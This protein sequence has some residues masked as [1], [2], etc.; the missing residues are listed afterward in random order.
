MS[1]FVKTKVK[2]ARDAIGKK[3]YEK[4]C[5]LALGVLEYEPDNYHANLFLGLAYF[6]LKQY[7]ESEQTYRKAIAADP[8]QTL[9]WQGILKLYEE[10]GNWAEVLRTLHKLVELHAKSNDAV[11]CAE[12]IQKII[13]LRRDTERLQSTRLELAE[14]LSLLLPDSPFYPV[15]STLP[16]PDPTNP[17][18]STTFLAQS[19]IQD[20]LPILQELVSIHEQEERAIGDAEVAKRRQRLGALSPEETRKQVALEI[21]S[22]S[23][24]P[25]LYNELLNHPNTSDDLRRETESKLL[26]MKQT[27]LFSIPADSKNKDKKARLAAEVEEL[28]N[29]IV[30]L[31]IPDELAWTLLIESK[32]AERIEDYDFDL[33][34]SFITLFPDSSLTQLLRAYFGYIGVPLTDEEENEEPTPEDADEELD[35]VD[36]MMDAF[37]SLEDSILAHRIIAE[38]YEQEADYQ[39]AIKTSESGLELV[40][41]VE[42]DWG[43]SI[44]KTKKAFKVILGTSLVHHFP[45]K[46]HS[47]ALRFI[48]EVLAEDPTNASA[49]MGRGFILQHAKKWSEAS[50]IFEKVA[51]LD[52]DGVEHGLRAKEEHAWCTAMCGELQAAADELREV[53]VTL[54]GFE[55]RDDDKARAWWRLGRCYWDM[56]DAYRDE[57][58]KHFVTALKR[59]PTFA[60]AFT[61]LGIYYSEYLSPPDP[62]RAS[63][64]F[65]KAFELDPR[66]AEAARRLAE[67]FAE[68]G[69][70]DL[71]EVVARRTIE[72]EGGLEDGPEAKASRRYLPINAWAWKAV[73][74]VEMFRRNYPPAIEAYQIALRTDVDDHMSWLRLGEAYSKAGRFAAAIKALERAHELDPNDWV[75]SYFIGEVQRQMGLYEEAIKAFEQIIEHRPQELGVL[76][77][78]GLSFLDLGRLELSTGFIA[79][80]ETSF[81]S[82]IRVTSELVA[83]SPG[84]RRV[85][86]KTIGDALLQLSSFATFTD[87][88]A[89]R[90]VV[91]TIVPLATEHPGKGLTNILTYPLALDDST[92]LPAFILQVALAAYDYKLSLGGLN[93]AASGAAH[94]DVGIA[95]STFARR[96]LDSARRERAEQEAIAQFKHALRLEPSNDA[97]WLAL[98]NATFLSQPPLCQHSYIRAIELDGKSAGAWTSL[99]MFYLQHKDV[100]LANEAFYKA[101]TLD[102]DYAL[103][104]VGQGLVATTNQHHKDA[105]A[106]FEHATGL[107]AAVPE[108][109]LEYATRLFNKVNASTKSRLASS[110]ALLPAFFV[111]DRYCKQRPRDATAL[112]L[113]GL[114]CERVGHVEL[115]IEMLTRAIAVLEAA[116]E[117]TED[118]ATERQFT[119]AHTNVARLRLAT[120]DYEGALESYQVAT[121]LLPEEPEEG[122]VQADTQALLAQCQFGSGLANFKLGNLQ[123]ALA[124]FEAAMATA[125]ENASI[126]GHVVVLLAQTLWAIGTEE[127]K[128]SAKAQLLQ[129]IE[130]DPE[131]L[132]AINTLAGMGILTDDDNLVDAALSEL[133]SLPIDQRHERDPER[134]VTYLLVQHHL[135]QGDAQQAV[136]VAEKAVHAEPERIDV[137]R[138]LASLT[139]QSGESS[140]ALAIL[141]GSAQTH[142]DFAQLR[143]SLAL[144][145]VALCLES[146]TGEE[147]AEALKLAQKC[148]MLSPWDKHG[149]QVLAYIRSQTAS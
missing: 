19:A 25:R 33:L 79:R 106:L 82:A 129:S 127:A 20:S 47:R 83:A 95:L 69:E 113:F 72:G 121:S 119:T 28:I 12:A 89:L 128:E 40:R 112:H 126:R 54:D 58:Y 63:K 99:G 68:E 93:D 59:S 32:D 34:R 15:L 130:Y 147:A 77:S 51:K 75:A 118:P 107:T 65:Q 94:Y 85:A 27:H 64:C 137:R 102:P 48:D 67:G 39:N 3:D 115:G 18:S 22:K 120:A 56:G 35:Y 142:S 145:S 16:A 143:R 91:S 42:Q 84:F 60:P 46:H 96:T 11:K 49:L 52:V 2:A 131:N 10:S 146:G 81:T 41:R 45:P 80:A 13:E 88:A 86:W 123:E 1:A 71:V 50:S 104:W 133:L 134:D 26:R 36:T 87:E 116:Y 141:G 117:E 43:R 149:W 73:G 6:N 17:T 57:A 70:W 61:S 37:S 76:H 138:K 110:E 125:G 23:K 114:V 53:I 74:A 21:L 44:N 97:F 100:E 139:L 122:G 62:N 111:L 109:D 136:A 55:G 98:G 38:L 92:S 30:L 14:A 7:N 66:E 78:L 135:G 132:M 9:A 31:K 90:E 8:N 148:V 5:E 105:S 103:A 101:Q 108:A 144:H 29:G 124:Q 4:A 140:A 24:L